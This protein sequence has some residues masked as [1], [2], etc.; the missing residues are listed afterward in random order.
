[1][2]KLPWHGETIIHQIFKLNAKRLSLN[3]HWRLLN[4]KLIDNG[5]ILSW[6]FTIIITQCQLVFGLELEPRIPLAQLQNKDLKKIQKI[7]LGDCYMIDLHTK[8]S[9]FW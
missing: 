7:N 8:V 2:L 6:I 5:I 9:T 1:M 3:K 4:D